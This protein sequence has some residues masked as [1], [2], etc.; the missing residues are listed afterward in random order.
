MI[1]K[2]ERYNLDIMANTII[3]LVVIFI[4]IICYEKS[5]HKIIDFLVQHAYII[6][7]LSFIYISLSLWFD[8]ISNLTNIWLFLAW[9]AIY[10]LFLSWLFADIYKKLGKNLGSW[11]RFTV[12]P[13]NF[14]SWVYLLAFI[15]IVG[16][17][18][19][20]IRIFQKLG[21]LKIRLD[22]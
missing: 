12:D 3:L 16:T 7:T 8:V 13:D 2:S 10:D 15:P 6:P 18:P 4:F 11:R 1:S 14:D 21:E 22:H 19:I 20:T 5:K 17:I 9:F